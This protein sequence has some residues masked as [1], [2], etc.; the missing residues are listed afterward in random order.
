[1]TCTL[2]LLCK[3]IPQIR[4]RTHAVKVK[5]ILFSHWQYVPSLRY[6]YVITLLLQL[7][8][9]ISLGTVDLNGPLNLAQDGWIN[10][11]DLWNNIDRVS[12]SFGRKL[13]VLLSP[14]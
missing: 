14:P 2:S 8:E 1:V 13:P 7:C 9:A 3:V 5:N 6:K 11:V 10:I 12:N 4:D